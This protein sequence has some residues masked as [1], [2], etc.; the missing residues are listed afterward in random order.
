M[1]RSKYAYNFNTCNTVSVL[2]QIF[3]HAIVICSIDN[4]LKVKNNKR[5]ILKKTIYDYDKMT[6][7][8]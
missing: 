4:Y 7:E 2:P 3:D 6:D 5:N 8:L 1:I